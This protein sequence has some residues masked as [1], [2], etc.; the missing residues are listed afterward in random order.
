M[1][2]ESQRQEKYYKSHNTVPQIQSNK[3]YY[4]NRKLSNKAK[5]YSSSVGHKYLSPA[6]VKEIIS[7]LVVELHSEMGKFLEAHY[8]PDVEIPLSSPH[9]KSLT[10]SIW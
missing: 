5:H 4:P 7:P 9:L 3:V 2:R 10:Q 6:L 1:K 8:I